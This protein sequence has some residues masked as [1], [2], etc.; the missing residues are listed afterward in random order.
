MEMSNY[1][2]VA[3]D[4]NYLVWRDFKPYCRHKICKSHDEVIPNQISQ[5]LNRP[6]KHSPEACPSLTNCDD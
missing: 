4:G 6:I 5:T 3:M 1:S 2:S